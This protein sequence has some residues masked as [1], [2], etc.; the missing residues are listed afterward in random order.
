M[1]LRGLLG[2]FG[3]SGLVAGA[4]S[5]PAGNYLVDASGNDLVDASGNNLVWV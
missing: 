3:L 1:A 4:E 2:L 5:V